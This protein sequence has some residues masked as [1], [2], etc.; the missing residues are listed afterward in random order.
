MNFKQIKD[1]LPELGILELR[2]LVDAIGEEFRIR[3][4]KIEESKCK[5][6]N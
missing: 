2:R 6:L 3:L 4:N 1:S 5:T